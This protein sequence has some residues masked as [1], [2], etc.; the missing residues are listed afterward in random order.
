[1]R[2]K[3]HTIILDIGATDD[4]HVIGADK[5]TLA[6]RVTTLVQ[7]IQLFT[8]GG[9]KAVRRVGDLTL[10]G[11]LGFTQAMLAPR[12]NLTLVSLPTRLSQGWT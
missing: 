9:V 4:I 12:S 7:P 2:P 10:K 1:M 8:T 11:V 5:A 6:E 3:G